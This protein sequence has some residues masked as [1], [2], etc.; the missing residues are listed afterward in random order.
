MKKKIKLLW[1]MV[2]MIIVGNILSCIFSVKVIASNGMNFSMSMI[3]PDNQIN[4]EAIYYDLLVQPSTTQDLKM[5]ITNMS[6]KTNKIKITPANAQTNE[7]GLINYVPLSNNDDKLD[8][9]SNISFTSLVEPTKE[10]TFRPLETKIVSM[11][12]T[13]PESKFDGEILGSF[14]INSSIEQE[15]KSNKN[16]FSNEFQINQGVLIRQNFKSIPTQITINDIRSGLYQNQLAIFTNIQNISP[17]LIKNVT[18]NSKI[19]KKNSNKVIIE[20]EKSNIDLAPYSVFEYPFILD[21]QILKPGDYSMDIKIHFDS[22]VLS[23]VKDF[24]IAKN[25]IYMSN[26][27]YNES[28]TYHMPF[29]K[30]GALII[31]LFIVIILLYTVWKYKAIFNK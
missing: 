13:I 29:F 3:M 17:K 24:N 30:L 21:H 22:D 2:N 6:D 31:C 9:P 11:K 25:D 1:L 16:T 20:Q 7:N 8:S 15:K 5:R 10:I 4:K 27:K 19:R 14:I 23:Y 12:L 26:A 18:I 28:Q